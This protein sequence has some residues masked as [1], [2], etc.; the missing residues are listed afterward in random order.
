MRF[1][2]LEEQV[3]FQQDEFFYAMPHMGKVHSCRPILYRQRM[4]GAAGRYGGSE[5]QAAGTVEDCQIARHR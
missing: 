3:L 4:L 1:F 2:A 5:P